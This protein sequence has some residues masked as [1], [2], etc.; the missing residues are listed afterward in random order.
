MRKLED[1]IKELIV[2]KT[3]FELS[4]INLLI[5]KKLDMKNFNEFNYFEFIYK[6]RRYK[7][8]NDKLEKL[9]RNEL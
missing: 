4:K 6:R 5:A 3:D 9:I 2:K 7:L 1:Y 8:V